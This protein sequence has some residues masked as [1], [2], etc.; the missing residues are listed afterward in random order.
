MIHC[1]EGCLSDGGVRGIRWINRLVNVS[2]VYV[3]EYVGLE[4]IDD[5][6]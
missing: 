2:I 5:G 6:I 1:A 4:E 3:G